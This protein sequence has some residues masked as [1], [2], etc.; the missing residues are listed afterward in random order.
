MQ[1]GARTPPPLH[2]DC[3]GG[4]TMPGRSVACLV[5]SLLLVGRAFAAPASSSSASSPPVF[6]SSAAAKS[7][8]RAVADVGDAGAVRKKSHACL[9]LMQKNEGP[10]IK[11]LFDSVKGFVDE[12]CVVDTGSTDNT[13]EVIKSIDMPGVLVQE[14]FVDFATSRNFLLDTC[15]A[16]MTCDYLLLLDA[17][18]VLHV[19]PEWDWAKI[20]KDVYEFIQVRPWPGGVAVKKLRQFFGRMLAGG[21]VSGHG[22]IWM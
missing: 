22:G 5:G 17:D 11:R 6:S 14:P 12:Y 21:V 3:F 15:R 20:D 18:M 9:A 19:S 13:V 8:V 1:V 10:I 2:S 16:R 7:D 4:R